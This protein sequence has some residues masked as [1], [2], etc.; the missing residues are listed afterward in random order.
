MLLVGD[1]SEADET[2][3]GTRE[4]EV[5]GGGVVAGHAGGEEDDVGWHGDGEEEDLR[6]GHGVR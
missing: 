2:D 5:G 1:E 3:E 4:D 6:G